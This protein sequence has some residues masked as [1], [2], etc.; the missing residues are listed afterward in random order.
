VNFGNRR[1]LGASDFRD[2]EENMKKLGL[3][4]LSGVLALM[5]GCEGSAIAQG[6]ALD[7][8]SLPIQPPVAAPVTELD[9]RNVTP[10]PPFN[11]TPP[12]GAPNVVIVLIRRH[13]LW[14]HRALRWCNRDADLLPIGRKRPAL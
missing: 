4:T 11:I 1:N 2:C 8:T 9:A 13:W 7:R 12:E 6:D 10:P 5:M 14:C 3:L